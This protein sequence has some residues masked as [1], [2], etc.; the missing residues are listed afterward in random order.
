MGLK[1]FG[2]T[3]EVKSVS[4]TEAGP[5]AHVL[6]FRLILKFTVRKTQINSKEIILQKSCK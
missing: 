5:S 4:F 3:V 2:E 6:Y 1:E